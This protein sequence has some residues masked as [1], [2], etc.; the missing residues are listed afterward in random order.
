MKKFKMSLAEKRPDVWEIWH[1]TKNGETK[2]N[3]VAQ[4]SSIKYWFLCKENHEWDTAAYNILDGT[5]CP[6]CSGRVVH[7]DNCLATVKPEIAKQWHPEK[8][9]DV[10]PY[11][12][13]AHTNKKYWWVCPRG[14][15]YP[16]SPNTRK[17]ALNGCQK[18]SNELH[19]SFPE[20][21]IFFYIKKIFSN[22]ENRKN[23]LI[24]K[25][26]RI[27]LD[28]FIPNL[29][30]AIE[31]DGVFHRNPRNQKIDERKNIFLKE[32]GISLVRLRIMDLPEVNN[33][34]ATVFNLINES[35]SEL[36]KG[37]RDLILFIKKNFNLN[38]EE[39]KLIDSITVDVVSEQTE[40]LNN[41]ITRE[42]K[43]NL[44]YQFPELVSEWHPVKNKNLKPEYFTPYTTKK[45]WWQC[46]VNSE[47]EWN[48]AISNRTLLGNGCKYCAGQV[49][50][51]ETCLATRYPNI[52]I[53]WDFK[54]NKDKTPFSSMPGS[55][56][57]VWWICPKEHS[58]DMPINKKVRSGLSCPICTGKRTSI[59]NCLAT[60]NPEL[61]K[62]W[63]PTKNGKD[64]PFDYTAG[65]SSK[66]FWWQCKYNSKHEWKCTIYKRH[67]RKFGCPYCSGKRVTIENSLL[68]LNPE[69]SKEWHPNKNLPLTPE[70]IGANSYEKV[71]WK[72]LKC[73]HEWEATVNSRNNKGK[74]MGICPEC[75]TRKASKLNNLSIQYPDLIKDWDY[76]K[77]EKTPN[78]YVKGSS[79]KVWWKCKHNHEE[80]EQI[81]YRVRR[82]GCG[83]CKKL[84]LL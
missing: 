4:S 51:K 1:P 28:I 82:N 17:N 7:I 75:S 46:K 26:K 76:S 25:S 12:V 29:N 27:E 54:N 36:S 84:K 19:T 49:A 68:T 60:V 44:A 70:T 21:S 81:R 10:T 15:D 64:T 78:Q 61:S 74:I 43:N 79:I 18:C 33:H 2:P 83:K 39:R 65:S 30:L 16:A 48:T 58:Y 9:G 71:W 5:G 55:S 56:K 45:V 23:I 62:E 57:V 8:N 13:T 63:H 77:N 34:G 31:Y 41:Y 80:E 72:C 42:K 3:E 53:Q 47:H 50:T 52:S 6:I 66:E 69:L 35:Y 40:I 11:D 32:N 59:E 22:A 24:D 73:P 37:I 14:H 38:N 20:Q 67:K